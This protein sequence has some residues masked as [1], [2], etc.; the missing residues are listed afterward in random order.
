M[1]NF[2]S[3]VGFEYKKIF[4]KKSVVIAVFLALIITV[5]SNIGVMIGNNPNTG[6]SH[7][8]DMLIDKGYTLALE[9]VPLDENLILEASEAYKTID[10]DVYPYSKSEEYQKYARPYSKVYQL[11]ESVY[12]KQGSGFGLKGMQNITKE[13]AN[14]YYEKRIRQYQLNLENN[15]FFTQDNID[16][17]IKIDS[18][19]QKPFVLED[20]SGYE[21]FFSFTTTSAFI[22]MLL[23][24]FII[25]PIFV[26]EYNQRTDSVILTTKNGKKSQIYAKIFTGISLSM[27][28]SI[29]FVSIGYLLCMSV[30]GFDGAF[31]PIQLHIPLLTYNFTMLEVVLLLMVTTSL[32][33]FLMAGICMF[34]SSTLNNSI[35]VL[36]VGIVVV[37]LG[38]FNGILPG[39][40][41]KI[42]Y[43]LPL[44]MGTYFDVIL[45]Q[46][47]WNILGKD[48]WL[49]QAVCIVAFV[50]G[51][52]LMGLSFHRFKRHEVG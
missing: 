16:R 10:A 37:L 42:K 21:Y 51:S 11:I 34:L 1:N 26:N 5:F 27:M 48:I 8:E 32:G 20:I 50:I 39:T 7:Y 49:Y 46:Y 44:P 6:R 52:L 4:L 23:I 19:V 35:V 2:W 45:H 43:F 15:P 13:E 40:F 25:S 22:I 24:A 3:L 31:A 30:Y 38:M 14:H 18:Q 9:D 33:G 17:I 36:G 29:S 12:A 41:E 47:S 28:I